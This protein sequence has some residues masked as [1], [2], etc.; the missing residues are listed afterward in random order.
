MNEKVK[1][2]IKAKYGTIKRFSQEIGIPQ[3]Q[4]YNKFNGSR[5]F[6]KPEKILIEL[7]LEERGLF[8][9]HQRTETDGDENW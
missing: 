8:D 5:P 3:Y 1:A 2:K 9:E 4:L 7:M 6:T